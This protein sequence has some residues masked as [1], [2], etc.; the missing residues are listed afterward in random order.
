MSAWVLIPS[1]VSLRTEFNEVSPN[2]DTGSDGAIGDSAHTSSSDHTPDEDSDILRDHDADSKN[3]VHALDIDSSGPWPGG[4]AWF[5]R[6]IKGIVD[7]ERERW[8]DPHDV[9]RLEYVIWN[10]RIASRSIDDFRWREY[11][12][13]ADDHTGHAHFSARYLTVAENDTRPWGLAREADTMSVQDVRDFFESAA[14]GVRGSNATAEQRADRERLKTVFRFA[15]GTNFADQDKITTTNQLQG[16][17]NTLANL[18]AETAGRVLDALGDPSASV[19][20]VA[21][22][23]RSVLGANAAAVG[24]LLQSTQP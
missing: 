1:L 21:A 9:C 10:K 11:H 4:A 19:E 14:A 7:R 20:D 17:A 13:T 22:V 15:L 18:P 24:R 3:E 16:I 5:D 2:R 12:G 23:L 6:A 8:L